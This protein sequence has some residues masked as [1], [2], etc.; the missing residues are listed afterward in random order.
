MPERQ[1]PSMIETCLPTR[2][3]NWMIAA[4][5]GR[6]EVRFIIRATHIY[7]YPMIRLKHKGQ[8]CR[9]A[10]NGFQDIGHF[11]EPKE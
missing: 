1:L 2:G 11:F 3:V 7:G 5:P 9:L 8:S 6:V 10:M 4:G